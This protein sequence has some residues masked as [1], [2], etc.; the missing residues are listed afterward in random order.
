MF[1]YM[2]SVLTAQFHAL[3]DGSS[4]ENHGP[5]FLVVT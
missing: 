4:G 5:F 1:E 2:S 3:S